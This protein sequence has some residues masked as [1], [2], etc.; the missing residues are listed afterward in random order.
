[1]RDNEPNCTSEEYSEQPDSL[2]SGDHAAEGKR[3][4]GE[5]GAIQGIL[6]PHLQLKS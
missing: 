3:T 5:G 6:V 2:L 4:L 1:M